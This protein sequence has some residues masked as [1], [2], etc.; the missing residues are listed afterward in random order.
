MAM[1]TLITD[2]SVD[3]PSKHLG[4]SDGDCFLAI[5]QMHES[6]DLTLVTTIP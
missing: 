4:D 6:A 5:A 2:Q 3:I 1:R